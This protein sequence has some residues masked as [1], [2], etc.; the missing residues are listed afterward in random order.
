MPEVWDYLSP[1]FRERSMGLVC[2]FAKEI[3]KVYSAVFPTDKVMQEIIDDGA[4]DA[5]LFLHHPSIWDIRTVVL[6]VPD[7][8]GISEM[9][10]G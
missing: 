3:K 7:A 8:K 1:N 9:V 6:R 10:W 5:M 2:D 4:T